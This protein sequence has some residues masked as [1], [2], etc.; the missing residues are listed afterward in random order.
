MYRKTLCIAYM[1]VENIEVVLLKHGQ[2][3]EDG[4][5]REKLPARVEH[6]ASVRIEIGLHLAGLE[7]RKDV[8][9]GT[10]SGPGYRYLG[11]CDLDDYIP[12]TE[13]IV[14]RTQE[15]MWNAN[16][17][18]KDVLESSLRYNDMLGCGVT[19]IP[20]YH[21]MAGMCQA[22]NPSGLALEDP[23]FPTAH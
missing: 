18:G 23:L 10:T 21:Q 9:T 22:R 19:C 1:P 2:K 17:K 6:E 3:I 13:L 5:H 8:T 4:L 16:T 20:A 11:G 12:T 7:M 15:N 14:V